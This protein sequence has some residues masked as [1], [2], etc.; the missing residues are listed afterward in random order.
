MNVKWKDRKS[1]EPRPYEC[2]SYFIL[3]FFFYF[4]G[5][6]NIYFVTTAFVGNYGSYYRHDSSVGKG[7]LTLMYNPNHKKHQ[8]FGFELL[9]QSMNL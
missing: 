8:N 6:L 3:F 4:F 2:L 1:T 7:F 5:I 9:S